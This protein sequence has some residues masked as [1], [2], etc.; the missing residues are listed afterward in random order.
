MLVALYHHLMQHEAPNT[1]DGRNFLVLDFI[2]LAFMFV[3]STIWLIAGR[4]D[5]PNKGVF[6]EGT[7]ARV[8]A[9]FFLLIFEEV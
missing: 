6:L 1:N 3:V 7:L 2:F 5:L 8:V 9:G 4:I